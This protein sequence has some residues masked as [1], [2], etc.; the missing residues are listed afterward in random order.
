MSVNDTAGVSAMAAILATLA[1][2]DR[3]TVSQLCARREIPRST[4]F[5]IVDKLLS[6]GF[7]SKAGQGRLTLGPEAVRLGY[8]RSELAELAGPAEALISWL[9]SETGTDVSLQAGSQT[10]SKTRVQLISIPDKPFQPDARL[11]VCTAAGQEV[12]ILQMKYRKGATRSDNAYA[13][14]CCHRARKS[15]E[16]YLQTPG[17]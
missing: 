6:A 9:R 2:H 13:L 10:R 8:A 12:A 3:Q 5:Q 7:L 15:L 14:H 16:A 1:E 11:P 4:A 17:E